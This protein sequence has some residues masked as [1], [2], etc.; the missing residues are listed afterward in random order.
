M[1]LYSAKWVLGI[2][3]FT[4]NSRESNISLKSNV[5]LRKMNRYLNTHVEKKVTSKV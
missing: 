5:M 3:P 1:T 2:F 4:A